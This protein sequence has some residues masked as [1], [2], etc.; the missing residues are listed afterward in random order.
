M[1]ASESRDNNFTAAFDGGVVPDPSTTA[2]I[3]AATGE[4]ITHGEF[5]TRVSTAGAVLRDVGVSRGDRVALFFPNELTYLAVFFGAMRIG[6][7]PV[8]VNIQLPQDTVEYVV[9]DSGAALAVTSG[10]ESVAE[11]AVAAADAC[12]RVQTLFV[13]GP[14]GSVVG[15]SGG[16]RLSADVDVRSLPDAMAA[17]EANAAPA[18]VASDDP[19]MQPY[20]SGS[21]GKPKGVVLTHGGVAWNTHTVG[22]AWLLDSD[23][24]GLAATPLYHKNAMPGVKAL[25][26][27]GGST[28]VMDGFEPEAV[29]RAIDRYDVTFITGVPAMFKMLLAERNA[30][31]KHDLSTLSFAICGS[32]PVSP[33]LH[34][35]FSD[36][37]D[38]PL[39]E[40]YGLTEGGPVV[41]LTPRWGINKPGSTG[42]SVP[43]CE[44]IVVDAETG[45]PVGSGTVGEL[46]VSNPGVGRYHD[47]P[48]ENERAFEE[49]D[50]RTFLRTGDLATKDADGY[51]S[52]V[53]RV[54]DMMIVGGEN[55]YPT[56]VEDLLL[57][58]DAVA[59][60]AVVAAPH[61]MKGEAPVA[62]VVVDESGAEPN[63]TE[64]TIKQY[65]LTNGP[66]YAHPRRVFFVDDLPLTGTEKVDRQR[67]EADAENRL[68][69]AL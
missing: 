27:R 21:T 68:D 9:D 42:L 44:T 23:E 22:D 31:A 61:E 69:G 37:F 20:T 66:A 39:L 19:A 32:A 59:D 16:D 64:E 43:G 40:A 4:Q 53:G 65:A 45:E 3:D 35:R 49:R 34:G 55:V 38:A 63:T 11:T 51:H 7:V 58:H 54:D 30:V 18:A 56:E 10:T 47:R 2:F 24:R 33:E 15:T 36:T 67:L 13:D 57:T 41:S 12:D 6:A 5:T 17:A 48:E 29:L 8:P 14:P 46:L 62:F 26:E 50:G 60:V 25:L 28:V 52:I 1:S